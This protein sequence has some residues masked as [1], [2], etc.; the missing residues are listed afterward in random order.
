MYR[1]LRGLI[2]INSSFPGKI[3][4]NEA[5]NKN[6]RLFARCASARYFEPRVMS[7]ATFQKKRLFQTD[8]MSRKAL[9]SR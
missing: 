2:M 9:F 6:E 4:P 7:F 3:I 5:I 1:K 8:Y